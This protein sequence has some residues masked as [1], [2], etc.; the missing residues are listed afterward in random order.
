MNTK[1]KATQTGIKTAARVSLNF[2]LKGETLAGYCLKNGIDKGQA[3]RAL[4]GVD[5]TPRAKALKE[6]LIQASK[7]PPE[8]TEQ[9]MT[10]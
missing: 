5:K 1:K 9:S 8:L 3:S 2:Q 6:H 10:A 7:E 4:R